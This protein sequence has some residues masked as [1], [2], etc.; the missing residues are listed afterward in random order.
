MSS[1]TSRPCADRR[2]VLVGGAA[3]LAAGLGVSP[4]RA[5]GP[6]EMDLKAALQKVVGGRAA[7]PGKVALDLPDLAGS[8]NSVALTVKVDSPMT[9]ADHVKRV[10]VFAEENPRPHVMTAELGPRAGRA[11]V[12]TRIRLNKSQ[13]VLVLVET[14]D[15]RLWSGRRAVEVTIGACDA[16]MFR[17]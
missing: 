10:H 3:C 5:I 12:S 16:L 6:E 14:A 1:P 7:T 8:G 15:G 13:S 11:E 2:R 17:Y 9:E 4:A